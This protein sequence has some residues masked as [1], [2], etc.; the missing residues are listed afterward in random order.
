M[1]VL[2]ASAL[3]ELLLGTPAGQ[4]L[5]DRLADASLTLHVPHLADVEIVQ[6]LR[7]YARHGEISAAEAEQA[8]DT[9]R[10]LDLDGMPT[11]R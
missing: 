10:S 1:I 5:A 11:S 3:I 7:R 8:I 6:A 4:R 2:D 9:L